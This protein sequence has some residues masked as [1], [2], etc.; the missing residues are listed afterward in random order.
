MSIDYTGLDNAKDKLDSI[1]TSIKEMDNKMR[2]ET[3]EG[4]GL[5]WNERKHELSD[6]KTTSEKLDG[7]KKSSIQSAEK[8]IKTGNPC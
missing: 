3:L 2:P 7:W 6:I 4:D 8:W 1:K 5:R